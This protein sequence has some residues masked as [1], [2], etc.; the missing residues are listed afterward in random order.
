MGNLHHT[1]SLLIGGLGEL[2]RFG[3][4]IGH[5]FIGLL[6]GRQHRIERIHRRA[7]QARLHIDTGDFDPQAQ[8][9]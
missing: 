4:R 5:R 1:V 3:A 6:T 8:A 2:F 7:R 9:A